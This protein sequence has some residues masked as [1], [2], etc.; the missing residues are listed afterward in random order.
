MRPPY[1][2]KQSTLYHTVVNMLLN[3]YLGLIGGCS[4]YLD[5]PKCDDVIEN[6]S[7]SELAS[8]IS[9]SPSKYRIKNIENF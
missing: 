8:T 2:R 4:L 5:L 6:S 3:I 9:L 1:Q 7:G